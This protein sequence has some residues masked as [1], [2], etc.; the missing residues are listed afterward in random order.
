MIDSP[1]QSRQV[2]DQYDPSEVPEKFSR[3]TFRWLVVKNV[4]FWYFQALCKQ[5]C[6]LS[7]L[8]KETESKYAE[9][10]CYSFFDTASTFFSEDP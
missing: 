8:P 2:V 6:L 4:H 10:V 9:E 5:F 1:D 7:P 3:A